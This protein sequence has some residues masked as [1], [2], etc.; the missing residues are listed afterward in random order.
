MPSTVPP[1]S[2]TC[3]GK[4]RRAVLLEE[5]RLPDEVA[6]VDAAIHYDWNNL[7]FAINAGNLFDET[8]ISSCFSP[9]S[10]GDR[11]RGAQV[12]ARWKASAMICD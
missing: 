6:L 3:G 2:I 8:F 10:G 5:A 4:T 12:V 11:N 9:T 7:R 1:P